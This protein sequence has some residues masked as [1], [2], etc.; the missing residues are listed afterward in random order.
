MILKIKEALTSVYEDD[1]NRRTMVFRILTLLSMVISLFMT[2]I[3]V[4]SAEWTLAKIT[5]SYGI[6]CLVNFLLTARRFS[7]EEWIHAI[8]ALE[9]IAMLSIFTMSGSADGFAVLWNLVVPACTLAIFGILRGTLFSGA[10]LLMLLFFFW[11]PLGQ[12]LMLYPY[13]ETFLMRFPL[14][15]LCMYAISLYVEAIRRRT[16]VRLREAEKNY[17]YMYRHDALTN[18]YSRHVFYEEAEKA[19]RESPEIPMG[20]LLFDIDDF[21]QI[22]DI[23]GHNVGDA[24]LCRMAEVIR[25]SICEHCL[26]CRWG[27]EEFLVMLKCEHDATAVAEKIRETAVAAVVPKSDGTMVRFTV[28]GGVC[29]G[30]AASD[31]QISNLI[32]NADQAMYQAK[33]SGKNRIVVSGSCA[34]SVS[35]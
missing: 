31:E 34:A 5:L 30:M 3:N 9:T 33:F 10:T 15:Y 4:V 13:N 35:K 11:C 12:P 1:A 19:S 29:A 22:N 6:L 2:V 24:V 28:S 14:L 17:K 32:H 27:G 26:A 25:S 21:K 16:F 23:H 7:L 18:L 20:I 8:F